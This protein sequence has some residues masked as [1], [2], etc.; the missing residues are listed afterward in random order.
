MAPM[1]CY[2]CTMSTMNAMITMMKTRFCWCSAQ[3]QCH[4]PPMTI[5]PPPSD[6]SI[7]NKF[8]IHWTSEQ[9]NS[10]VMWLQTHTADC[11]ILF[12]KNKANHVNATEKPMGNVTIFFLSHVFFLVSV[13]HQPYFHFTPLHE[14]T[15]HYLLAF[16]P[17]SSSLVIPL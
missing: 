2:E 1:M 7:P 5:T 8:T 4:Q 16:L 3:G 15:N 6:T 10:L 14:E 9:T 12:S 11:N 17:Y 13:V